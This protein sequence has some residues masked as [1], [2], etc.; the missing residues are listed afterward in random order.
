MEELSRESTLRFCSASNRRD[1]RA[2][3]EGEKWSSRDYALTKGLPGELNSSRCNFAVSFVRSASAVAFS[4]RFLSCT[5]FSL[6][7]RRRR[8]SGRRLGA[9]IDKTPLLKI[10]GMTLSADVS[11]EWLYL[12]DKDSTGDCAVAFESSSNR[13]PR[14]LTCRRRFREAAE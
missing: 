1:E 10:E 11:T 14:G 9:D 12:P 13:L 8:I 7:V 3:F 6:R 4:R 2:G 5:I